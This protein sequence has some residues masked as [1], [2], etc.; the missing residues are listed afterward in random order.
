MHSKYVTD[1]TDRRDALA[2]D[3]NV[4]IIITGGKV[5]QEI[6]FDKIRKQMAQL[7]ELK[8]VLVDGLRVHEAETP[9]KSVRQVCPK[10]VELDLSRN[11]FET[12]GEIVKI[13]RDLDHLKSLTFK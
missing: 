4:E 3:L 10:I 6:G 5:A 9:G 1:I 12:V 7:D 8:I 2:A 11:L 13:C